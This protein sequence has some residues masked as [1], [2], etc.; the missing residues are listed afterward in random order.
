MISHWIVERFNVKKYI[1]IRKMAISF[2]VLLWQ[3]ILK[4]VLT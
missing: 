1:S 2:I 4:I 3:R